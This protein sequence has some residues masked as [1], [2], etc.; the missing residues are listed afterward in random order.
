MLSSQ[1]VQAPSLVGELRSCKPHSLAKEKQVVPGLS[2]PALVDEVALESYGEGQ[3]PLRF[4]E[5]LQT[6]W[7][8]G[9]HLALWK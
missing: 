9:C 1:R 5:F 2:S 6:L 4:R 7:T 3:S 8:S